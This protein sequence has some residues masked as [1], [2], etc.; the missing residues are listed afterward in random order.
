VITGGQS[1]IAGHLKIGKGAK[2]AAQAGIL[3][4]LPAGAEVMGTPA[5]PLRQFFRQSFFVQKMAAA[6]TFKKEEKNEGAE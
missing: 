3:Q 4:D 6:A 5:V 2:I 1:G